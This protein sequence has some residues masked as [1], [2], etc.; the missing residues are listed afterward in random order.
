MVLSGLIILIIL[1][2]QS[3]FWFKESH[4]AYRFLVATCTGE[5]F[6]PV[7]LICMTV[8][9]SFELVVVI[10]QRSR[11]GWVE[12]KTTP[13]GPPPLPPPRKVGVTSVVRRESVDAGFVFPRLYSG[14]HYAA[15]L[16]AVRVEVRV[17][18]P[19]YTRR[20]TCTSDHAAH[21][22]L[23]ILDSE[24]GNNIIIEEEEEEEE[25]KK[26]EEEEEEEKEEEEKDRRDWKLY[27]PEG[28]KDQL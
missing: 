6:G 24:E 7:E 25:E 15:R 9:S 17:F 5:L 13:I 2:F 21:F 1:K 16:R 12:E 10:L 26:E 20:A 22:P 27:L 3:I 8:T 11:E 19:R 14:G 18:A 4:S 28:S 23:C